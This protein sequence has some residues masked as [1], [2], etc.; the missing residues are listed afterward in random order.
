[1]NCSYNFTMRNKKPDP[2]FARV[3]ISMPTRMARYVEREAD[4]HHF[5]NVSLYFR[6]LIP[7]DWRANGKNRKAKGPQHA[8]G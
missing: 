3:T 2:E 4:L 7:L 5:G 8:Q 1:M 6:R